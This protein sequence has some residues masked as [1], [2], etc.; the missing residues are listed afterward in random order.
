MAG[1]HGVRK[2]GDENGN[3]I[4]AAVLVLMVKG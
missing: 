4:P 1:F 3:R 2:S